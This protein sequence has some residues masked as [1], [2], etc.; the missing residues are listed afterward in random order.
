[1]NRLW[2]IAA[3]VAALVV[4]AV[5]LNRD[6]RTVDDSALLLPALGE[7]L[8][9]VTRLRIQGADDTVTLVREDGDWRV[10]ERDYPAKLGEVRKTLIALAEA[11]VFEPK[12]SNPA[13]YERLGVQ[14][15]VPGDSGNTQVLLWS[16]EEQLPG[17]IVGEH[18]T[19]PSGT[20]VRVIGQAQSALVTPRLGLIQAPDRWLVPELTNI[21]PEEIARIEVE[22]L[23]SAPY[24]IVRDDDG[25]T[26]D[27]VPEGK[28]QKKASVARVTRVLQN[29]RLDDVLPAGSEPA[30]DAWHRAV[31]TTTNGL[32]I[33]TEAAEHDG[34]KL[35]K[36]Q[37]GTAD[38]V[39]AP[40]DDDSE[41][42]ADDADGP[43]ATEQAEAINAKAAG[44]VFV[45]QGYKF[46]D[47]TLKRDLLLD[48]A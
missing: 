36:L 18:A 29:L 26:L 24:L 41:A 12:T 2:I 3:I 6:T 1:M 28:N 23:G 47:A 19:Q 10:G 8:N 13:L 40:T 37:A 42:A 11:T 7:Q 25:L 22:P 4:G 48:D 34:Q 17:L 46:N 27:S 16:G 44:R 5:A 38:A 14:D 15:F 45:I 43:S 33:V 39:M 35:L 21:A 32:R 30:I 9:A 20:Y 31:F